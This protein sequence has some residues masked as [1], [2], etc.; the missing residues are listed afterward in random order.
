MQGENVKYNTTLYTILHH[1]QKFIHS[2]EEA[3]GKFLFYQLCELGDLFM[4][5]ARSYYMCLNM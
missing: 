5:A 2:S 1:K 4:L 3:R